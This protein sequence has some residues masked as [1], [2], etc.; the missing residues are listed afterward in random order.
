MLSKKKKKVFHMRINLKIWDQ[1]NELF[2]IVDV[3]FESKRRFPSN[4]VEEFVPTT[5]VN[6][7][8]NE[9]IKSSINA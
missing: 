4:I 6:I 8:S 3:S 7:L 9:I 1:I 2:L 5:N